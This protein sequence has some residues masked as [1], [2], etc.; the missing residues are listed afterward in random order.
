MESPCR[1]PAAVRR[2]SRAQNRREPS[3]GCR[4]VASRIIKCWECQ[5]A[6]CGPATLYVGLITSKH[7]RD[8]LQVTP[9]SLNPR[10]R[11]TKDQQSR[12]KPAAS[13]TEPLPATSRTCST[14]G[15]RPK[16]MT[17]RLTRLCTCINLH[18]LSTSQLPPR[19]CSAVTKLRTERAACRA[20]ANS[21][22]RIQVVSVSR[23]D[24][25]TVRATASTP[26]IGNS[27]AKLG[28]H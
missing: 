26:Q 5:R 1:T 25:A 2:P 13:N 21:G 14:V 23:R 24:C 3:S 20:Q 28:P 16:M 22:R 27:G 17:G 7:R 10:A 4:A 15:A 19:D 6:S 12:E 11:A 9:L 18:R 8:Q